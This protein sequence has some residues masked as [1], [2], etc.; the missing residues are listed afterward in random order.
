[1]KIKL[2][3]LENFVY[4]EFILSLIFFIYTIWTTV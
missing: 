4:A 2:F 1:M 3:T